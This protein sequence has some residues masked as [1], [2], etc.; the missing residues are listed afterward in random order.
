[1]SHSTID[2]APPPLGTATPAESP[3]SVITSESVTDLADEELISSLTRHAE[4]DPH[5]RMRYAALLFR[6][7]GWEVFEADAEAARYLRDEAGYE[8]LARETP[9]LSPEQR[10]ARRQPRWAD[11]ED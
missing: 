7:T 8:Q 4:P 5:A 9:R 6:S 3:L 1:M 10:R 11:D 2:F